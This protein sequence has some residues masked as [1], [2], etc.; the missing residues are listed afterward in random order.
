MFVSSHNHRAGQLRIK[1]Y[2]TPCIAEDLLG[3]QG[4]WSPWGQTR[5]NAVIDISCVRLLPCQW[6]KVDLAQPNIY[7][8]YFCILHVDPGERIHCCCL[9]ACW[10]RNKRF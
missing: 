9:K 10:N 2:G 7:N 5:N 3:I 6:L 4:S 1:I 8:I